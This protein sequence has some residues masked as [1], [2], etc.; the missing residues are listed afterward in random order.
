MALSG[1]L[2]CMRG[3]VP[4]GRCSRVSGAGSPLKRERSQENSW[5]SGEVERGRIVQVML[6]RSVARWGVCGSES[7]EGQQRLGIFYRACVCLNYG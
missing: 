7:S 2:S 1:W 6:C 4:G 5:E 3:Q